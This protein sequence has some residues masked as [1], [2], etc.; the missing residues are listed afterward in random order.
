MGQFLDVSFNLQQNPAEQF[1]WGTI[2]V[3]GI[4]GIRLIKS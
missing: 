2:Y 3:Y 1:E 4:E